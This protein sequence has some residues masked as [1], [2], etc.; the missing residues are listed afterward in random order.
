MIKKIYIAKHEDECEY[1]IFYSYE[2]VIDFMTAKGYYRS[3]EFVEV[4]YPDPANG[5]VYMRNPFDRA[6]HRN[7]DFEPITLEHLDSEYFGELK[8]KENLEIRDTPIPKPNN[9][10]YVRISDYKCYRVMAFE[11]DLDKFK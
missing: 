11:I 10:I 7:P 8:N 2:E 4:Y 6:I 3:K 9:K 5:L 1:I